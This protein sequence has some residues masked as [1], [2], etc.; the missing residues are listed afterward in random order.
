MADQRGYG[1]TRKGCTSSPLN[2]K[3]SA[4]IKTTTA[5]KTNLPEVT[6]LQ[7]TTSIET[8]TVRGKCGG[9]YYTKNGK[10]YSPEFPK[11]YLPGHYCEYS[12]HANGGY[13]ISLNFSLFD[14]RGYSCQ[15]DYIVVRDG[16]GS[17][18]PPR[19]GQCGGYIEGRLEGN[20]GTPY[21]PHADY[22][23]NTICIY[24]ISVPKD[25]MSC[26]ELQSGMCGFDFVDVL[27]GYGTGK[28]TGTYCGSF[29][30][31]TG[32]PPP[33]KLILTTNSLTLEFHSDAEYQ[34]SGFSAN[35]EATEQEVMNMS[36]CTST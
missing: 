33:T 25:T 18:D 28:L 8:T 3:T 26:F 7:T 15:Y 34:Y 29:D 22:P 19:T 23:P 12:I 20:I 9:A 32:Q 30:Y 1:S 17:T 2:G 21:Y 13:F 16:I 10:F 24:V 27:D 11:N 5:E 14:L 36:I 6:T 4:V 31:G 35:F